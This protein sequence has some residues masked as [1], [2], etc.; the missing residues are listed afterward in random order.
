MSDTAAY[1]DHAEACRDA[2]ARLSDVEK[3]VLI[4]IAREWQGT[5]IESAPPA[6]APTIWAGH[7]IGPGRD[8]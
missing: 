5:A 4:R 3:A 8:L 1:L 2:A 7:A 6:P